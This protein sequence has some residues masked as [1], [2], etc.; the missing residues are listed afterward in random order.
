MRI[1]VGMVAKDARQDQGWDRPEQGG[2]LTR[3]NKGACAGGV[4]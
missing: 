2:S 4:S 1:G 3:T